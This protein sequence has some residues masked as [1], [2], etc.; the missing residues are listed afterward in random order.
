MAN[1]Q[2]KSRK[3]Q[4]PQVD[5][6]VQVQLRSMAT[7][8][9]HLTYGEK[10]CP[11]WGTLFREIEADGMPVKLELARLLIEQS[12]SGPVEQMPEEAMQV[13]DDVAHPAGINST[14]HR[15]QSNATPKSLIPNRGTRHS[16]FHQ[17]K[18]FRRGHMI[19]QTSL[20][21]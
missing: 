11:E 5:P 17:M 4:R 8:L 2:S 13:P 9:R 12:T 16:V 10:G 19:D 1:K 15:S 21:P 20:V 3:T 14:Q 6:Q 18:S 7:E